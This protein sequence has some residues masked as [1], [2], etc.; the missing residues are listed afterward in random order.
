MMTAITVFAAEPL[1]IGSNRELFVDYYLIEKLDNVRLKLAQ[2]VDEGAAFAYDL[3]WEGPFCGYN[4]MLKDGDRYLAYY[5]G[6][7]EFGNKEK[8]H[9]YTCVALSD[10]GVNWRKPELGIVEMNGSTAN[11]IIF[12]EEPI[13]HNFSVLLD[14][15]PGVPAAERFKALGGTEKSGLIALVS[16]DGI[17]WKKWRDKPVITEGKFDSQNVAFWSELEQCYVCYFRTWTGTGYTGYRTI[18][19]ATSQDFVNWTEPVR[20]SFGKTPLEQLYINQTQPYFRAPQIYIALAARF[21]GKRQVVTEEQAKEL[22]VFKKYYTDCSDGVM[23]TSRGGTVYDRTFMEGFIRP[24]LSLSDWVSRTNYPALNVL[25]TSET[26]ISIYVNSNYTQPTS[27]LRRFSLRLDGFASV[28][29]PY[30]GGELIT[31]CFTFDGTEL[32]LNFATSAPG[33]I[34]VEI[35]DEQGQAIPGFTASE[36]TPLIGNFIDKTASWYHGTGVS[37]L[38]GKTVRLRFVMKDADLYAIQFK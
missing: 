18:S 29:A 10:D 7:Y 23:L 1:E 34:K 33:E 14:K 16:E 37:E 38:A 28:K 17:H 31:K 22:G 13:T 20:M 5:R 19:R 2:P 36:A 4:T 24:G 15:K 25:Q 12:D 8:E 30:A 9:Q 35:Q 6:L 21:M 26:E 11:N 27:Y 32:H 3:L